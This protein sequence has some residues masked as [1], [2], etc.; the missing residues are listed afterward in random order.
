MDYFQKLTKGAGLNEI[1]QDLN[2]IEQDLNEIEQD[3]NVRKLQ[4]SDRVCDP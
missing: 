3:L 2:E 4:L 1:E